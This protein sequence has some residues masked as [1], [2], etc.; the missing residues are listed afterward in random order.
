MSEEHLR[1]MEEIESL[2]EAI[3]LVWVTRPELRLGQLLLNAARGWPD[4]PD[5]FNV[6][7]EEMLK[8]L[9]HREF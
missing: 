1:R 4:W 5:I 3:F 6:S 8:R 7:D 2:L 9:E